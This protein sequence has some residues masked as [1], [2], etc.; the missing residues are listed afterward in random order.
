[1][2]QNIFAREELEQSQK[3]KKKKKKKFS[4]LK[5]KD[6]DAGSKL[7]QEESFKILQEDSGFNPYSLEEDPLESLRLESPK[8]T[9][10]TR[11]KKKRNP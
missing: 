9:V 3:L 6:D 1:M 4:P 11:S 2:A 10:N 7:A 8:K 5:R